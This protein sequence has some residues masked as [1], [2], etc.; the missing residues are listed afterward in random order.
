MEWLESVS[1]VRKNTQIILAKQFI[2]ICHSN[3]REFIDKS[4]PVHRKYHPGRLQCHPSI[5][6]ANSVRR[7]VYGTDT[8]QSRIRGA[9]RVIC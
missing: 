5:R 1:T 7:L 9:H 4:D 8:S 3:S 2:P 6:Q